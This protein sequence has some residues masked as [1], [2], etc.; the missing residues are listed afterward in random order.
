M[1]DIKVRIIAVDE[2]TPPLKKAGEAMEAVGKKAKEAT[3]GLEGMAQGMVAMAGGLGI[4]TG[5]L[6]IVGSIK[7]MAVESVMLAAKL[8][9][10]TVGFTTMLGSGEKASKMLIDLRDFAAKTPF[11][12]NELT[13]AA[14]KMMAMGT[15]SKDVIPTLRA[16]GDASAALGLGAAGVDRITYALGQM[17][18]KGKIGGD[19]IR[20]LAEAGVPALKYLA[21]AAGV[22][23]AAMQKMVSDGTVPADQGVKILVQ[24]MSADFGGLMAEQAKTATGALSNLEDSTAS[25]GT[26]IGL[27]L[28]PVV[29]TAAEELAEYFL[30]VAEGMTSHR[31]AADMVGKLSD[32]L[33]L[34]AI[35]QTEFESVTSNAM[36]TVSEYT[37]KIDNSMASVND[38]EAATQLLATAQFRMG[39]SFSMGKGEAEK[40]KPVIDKLTIAINEQKVA[41]LEAKDAAAQL[42]SAIGLIGGAQKAYEADQ[43]KST[44]S[45]T[46]LDK[47][48]A[49]LTTKHAKNNAAVLAGKGTIVDNTDALERQS[50]SAGFAAISFR[51][52]QERFANQDGINTFNTGMDKAATALSELQKDLLAG[53]IDTAEF[54][55]ASGKL[56]D[57][58]NKL[59][60]NFARSQMTQEEYDLKL[61]DHAL[62]TKEASEKTAQLTESNNKGYTAAELA[63]QG[64]ATYNTKLLELQDKLKE[65]K[66]QDE[67]L[68]LQVATRIKEGLVLQ[69]LENAVKGGLTEAEIKRIKAEMEAFGI[70]GSEAVLTTLHTMEAATL[71]DAANTKYGDAFRT[72]NKE[73]AASFTAYVDSLGKDVTNK[74]EPDQKRAEDAVNEALKKVK[75]FADTYNGLQSK[76]IVLTYKEIRESSNIVLQNTQMAKA[77]VAVSEPGLSVAVSTPVEKEKVI[78]G[79]KAHGGPVLGMAGSYLV[80]EQGPELFNPSGTGGTIVP[81][82]KLGSNGLSIDTLNLYGVQNISELFNQLAKEARARG[83]RFSAN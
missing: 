18:A 30:A 78:A 61:R 5:L 6:S 43:K 1:A 33:K 65:A 48:I 19:D 39:D 10:T 66:K 32:A 20:Q 21:D 42:S 29:K 81:N 59:R 74:L 17:T 27:V 13:A 45:I 34:G 63:A 57:Q 62:D 67:L 49:D 77:G 53:T 58:Q 37:G 23:T 8:E 36:Q 75:L 69:D 80:G 7:G 46:Q 16:V 22:T 40:A 4:Q 50:I 35:D 82:N 55:I 71:L 47:A 3:T 44:D 68:Q 64:T 52:L 76:E 25:L 60:E 15:A 14:S 28:L 2:A 31:A 51:N 26:E 73:G 24:S 41:A 54:D 56:G 83:L 12:F 9:T 11:Q 38:M 79:K 72:G 70:Q